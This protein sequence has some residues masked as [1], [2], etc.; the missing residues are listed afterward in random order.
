VQCVYTYY[1]AKVLV[2]GLGDFGDGAGGA[3][4]LL[5]TATALVLHCYCTDDVGAH[6]R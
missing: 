6:S 2:V 3:A 5:C 1:I 4:L